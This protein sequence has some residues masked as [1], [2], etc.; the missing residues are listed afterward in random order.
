MKTTENHFICRVCGG[1]AAPKGAGTAHR[2]HCP[3]CLA[4]I[5]LDETPGD[6]A[7]RCGGVMDPIGVWVRK[8]GEWAVIHRCRRCGVLHS[9]RVAADDNPF[10]LLSI[11]VKPLANPPFPIEYLD[12]MADK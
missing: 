6:R 5:H 2:N 3:H 1:T 9:N 12:R 7:S 11:A 4:S 10:R 8:D